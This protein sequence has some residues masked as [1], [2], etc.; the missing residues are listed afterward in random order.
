MRFT[1]EKFILAS[2]SPRRRELLEQIGLKFD[3]IVSSEK[4]DNID[5]SLPPELYTCELA[6]L[7]A[8]STAK[9]LSEQ[10]RKDCIVI[11]ADTIVYSD[12][13]ILEKPK[14][15]LDAKR[16]LTSLSA[17][18]HQVYTGICVMRMKDGYTISKSQKTDVTFKSLDEKTINAYIQ[19]NEPMDKAGAYG[20]QG[21]GTMLIE[22][23]EGDYFNVV[24]L[25]VS[26][27]YDILKDEFGINILG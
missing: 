2:A 11:S 26:L 24:G 12:G 8:T 14:D 4:E 3:I 15:E 20:I 18:T 25:P 23:I 7:K 9:H 13:K 17:K 27:L 5:K 6:L 21:L 1:M 19:S 22:K 10:K 16:I